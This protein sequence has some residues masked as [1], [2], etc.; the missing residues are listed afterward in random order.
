MY[1]PNAS[2]IYLLCIEYIPIMEFLP[3]NSIQVDYLH[4]HFAIYIVDLE[5]RIDDRVF[6]KDRV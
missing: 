1:Q 4:K 6:L 3:I 5:Y 2:M